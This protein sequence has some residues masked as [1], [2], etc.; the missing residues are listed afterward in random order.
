VDVVR[1]FDADP[2]HTVVLDNGQPVKSNLLGTAEAAA[3]GTGSEE[4]VKATR[5]SPDEV[6]IAVQAMAPGWVILTDAF[7]PGWE[8]TVD[9]TPASILPAYSA[10]RA[11]AVDSGP[12]II[13]MRF[14][15][16][17]FT[18]GGW[19]TIL[20]LAGSAVALGA[21]LLLQRR[22]RRNT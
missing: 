20:A 15:P 11:V 19:V 1:R 9:G 17:S 7:Y 21:L 18:L 3:A 13:A 6:D 10:Y 16:A 2:R 8:A 12:H 5:Y 14:R 22:K 4:S